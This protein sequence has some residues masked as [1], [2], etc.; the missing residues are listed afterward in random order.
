MQTFT[1]GH[2]TL[3]EK[4]NLFLGICCKKYGKMK[5]ILEKSG[6]FDGQKKWVHEFT[7]NRFGN[8]VGNCDNYL[9]RSEV[10]KILSLAPWLETG[11][12][13]RKMGV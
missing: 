13:V 5:K 4:K 8:I 3:T 1:C 9:K 2:A 6:K 11:Q 10:Y 12:D 7:I